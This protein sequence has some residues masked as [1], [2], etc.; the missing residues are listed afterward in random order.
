[1]S[2]LQQDP[3]RVVPKRT[4]L[5]GIGITVLLIGASWYF[6]WSTLELIGGL[7]IGIV[8]NLITFRLIVVGTKNY[9]DK[10]ELGMRVS[11][12]PNLITRM[13]L[14]VVALFGALQ[15]GTYA[16]LAAIVGVSTVKLAI[17]LDN[18]VSIGNKK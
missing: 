12:I 10:K 13:V 14:L 7:W 3:I 11:M 18:F 1:M 6:G 2:Q 16:F 5:V 4:L 17:Q 15:L 9:L 8:T